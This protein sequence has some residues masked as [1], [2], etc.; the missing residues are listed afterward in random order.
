MI[1]K[2]IPKGQGQKGSMTKSGA[3]CGRFFEPLTLLFW[4]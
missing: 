1:N 4:M 2:P 3:R